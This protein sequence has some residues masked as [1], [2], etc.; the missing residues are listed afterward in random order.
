MNLP[1]LCIAR[2]NIGFGKADTFD[3]SNIHAMRF[4]ILGRFVLVIISMQQSVDQ[5]K[6]R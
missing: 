1:Y 2:T 3:A 4:W 6:R 5:K